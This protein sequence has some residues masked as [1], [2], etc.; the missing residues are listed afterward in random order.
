MT[1]VSDTEFS[2]QNAYSLRPTFRQEDPLGRA[3]M[4]DVE[5]PPKYNSKSIAERG[6]K[7]ENLRWQKSGSWLKLR[8]WKF[9]CVLG[10]PCDKIPI[11]SSSNQR[12]LPASM[13]WR[14]KGNSRKLWT[15]TWGGILIGGLCCDSRVLLRK[16]N[17][18]LFWNSFLKSG[19]CRIILQIDLLNAKIE[20]MLW[21][22]LNNILWSCKTLVFAHNWH[23]MTKFRLW[24][25]LRLKTIQMYLN[26]YKYRN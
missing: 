16:E 4:A 3:V 25:N 18:W 17:F 20:D 13:N 21:C 24:L 19:T 12:I 5:G 14:P 11:R 6:F 7:G 2:T 22:W 15:A 23:W 10:S 26:G 1:Y 8:Y 9:L